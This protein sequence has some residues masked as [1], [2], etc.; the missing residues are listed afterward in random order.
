M[1]KTPEEIKKGLECCSNDAQMCQWNCPF[2][3]P[4][5]PLDID[6]TSCLAADSLEYIRQLEQ[7]AAK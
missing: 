6:C 7:E 5:N 3:D 2:Y 1:M 4:D